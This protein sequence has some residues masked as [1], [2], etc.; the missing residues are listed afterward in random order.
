MF[1][2]SKNPRVKIVATL[3][4][5]DEADI[6]AANIEHHI[7][8][9]ISQFLITDNAST[10]DTRNIVGKYKE[11]VEIF[12]SADPTHNQEKHVTKMAREACK[13]DP[14]WILHIDA[15]EFAIGLD[16]LNHVDVFSITLFQGWHHL[17]TELDSPD[18][19][20]S[21]KWY[22]D[23]KELRKFT[24]KTSK[25]AH[26]PDKEIIISHGNHYIVNLDGRS[27]ITTDYIQAHHFPLRT[28]K[29]LESKA[30]NGY[31]GLVSRGQLSERWLYWNKLFKKGILF[32]EYE[33]N[34][35]TFKDMVNKG[36]IDSRAWKLFEFNS[37]DE[38]LAKQFKE[39][40]SSVKMELK[41]W[42]PITK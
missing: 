36:K 33:N 9:G 16:Y 12:D 19:M 30:T 38:E 3:C 17:A 18:W 26:R 32:N 29:Q 14:D 6:I 24:D 34:I 37:G 4:V 39:I 21:M 40:Q 1:F 5:K 41:S 28:Y 10:D 35:N 11:V 23:F 8:Q 13:L 31:S 42:N 22:I 27:N 25:I 7:E 15:D 20:E 2:V